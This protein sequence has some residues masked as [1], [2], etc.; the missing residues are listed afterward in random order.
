MCLLFAW[1]IASRRLWAQPVRAPAPPRNP[2]LGDA[3][4]FASDTC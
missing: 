2:R 1:K 4:F 3:F